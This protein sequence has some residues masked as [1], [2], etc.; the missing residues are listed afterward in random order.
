MNTDQKV[1]IVDTS[2]TTTRPVWMNDGSFLVF[3]KLHQDVFKFDALVAKA[4]S[5]G[6]DTTKSAEK[7]GAKLMGRWKSGRWWTLFEA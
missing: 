4:S 2:G 5:L 6:D 7:L 3:R 1:I